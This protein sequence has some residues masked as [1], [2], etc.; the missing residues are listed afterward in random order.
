MVRLSSNATLFFR[1]FFPTAW[2]VFFGLFTLAIWT[3]REN[4]GALN[5][6][7]FKGGT[8]LFFL[9]GLVF[10]YFTLFR[11]RRIESDGKNLFVTNYFR[12]FRYPLTEVDSYSEF[13]YFFF[14]TGHFHLKNKGSF[15]KTLL[16]IVSKKNMQEFRVQYPDAF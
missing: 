14:A 12:T 16:F 3:T 5:H 1:L 4:L 10:F 11:L 7:Y 8:T 15:G 9:S 13:N 2:I 6:L